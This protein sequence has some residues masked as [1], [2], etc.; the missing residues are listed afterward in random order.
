MQLLN[1]LVE[2]AK[3]ATPGEWQFG[4][5][6]LSDFDD[7]SFDMSMEW[8]AN[9]GQDEGINVNEKN[10]GAFIAAANPDAILAIAEYVNGLENQIADAGKMMGWVKCSERMPEE[11]TEVLVWGESNDT[12]QYPMIGEWDPDLWYGIDRNLQICDKIFNVTHWQPLP[13]PPT[14]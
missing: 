6:S 10:D 4:G 12:E 11:N 8:I 9:G 7:E 13:S 2:L 1:E 5:G 14:E 3:K